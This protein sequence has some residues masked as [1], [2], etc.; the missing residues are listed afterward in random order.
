[1]HIQFLNENKSPKPV[2]SIDL[3]SMVK[4]ASK[5]ESQTSWEQRASNAPTA[6]EP[7]KVVQEVVQLPHSRKSTS[8]NR[9]TETNT[10]EVVEM[11]VSQCVD[12]QSCGSTGDPIEVM[13][14]L[15]NLPFFPQKHEQRDRR[16]ILHLS[17]E[18]NPLVS[19]KIGESSAEKKVQPA[20][21]TR[22]TRPPTIKMK[23]EKILVLNKKPASDL[24]RSLKSLNSYHVMAS[25]ANSRLVKKKIN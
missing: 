1:M 11:E 12:T 24:Q 5:A 25:P 22:A 20:S 14:K 2:L 13:N 16:N 9:R 10:S 23:T 15:S 8:Q 3:E 21:L 6:Q 17:R 7:S 18:F 19:L 4:I